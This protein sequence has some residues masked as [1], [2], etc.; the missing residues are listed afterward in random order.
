MS[1]V[2]RYYTTNNLLDSMI[3]D[4]YHSLKHSNPKQNEN[5]TVTMNEH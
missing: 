4:G 2:F 5:T 1:T 3:S